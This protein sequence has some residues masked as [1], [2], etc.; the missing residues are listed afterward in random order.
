MHSQRRVLERFLSPNTGRLMKTSRVATVR[1]EQIIDAAIAVI[2]EQGIQ[3][4]SL[5]EIEKKTGL[6][7]GQLMYY[8]HSKEEILLAVF[9]RLL[10]L[11]RARFQ[12]SN[13][14]WCAESLQG[15]ERCRAFL[16]LFL[17]Q[18]PNFPAFHSLH[19]TFLSQ[20]GH[21]DDF[22]QRLA[23]L[24]D[25]WRVHMAGDL[26]ESLERKPGA[27]KASPRVLASLVQAIL[28]GL[29][30]QRAADPNCYDREE[31]LA[32]VLEL[33]DGYLQPPGGSPSNS[34]GVPAGAKIKKAG[35]SQ[36]RGHRPARAKKVNHE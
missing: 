35:A 21:R 28:H 17:L 12:A 26:Q 3:N 7:R 24:Y 27:R 32:L 15:W 5:S 31:M 20:I 33:L 10:Q 36:P 1:R 2:D 6:A 29:G 8:Y 13:G 25:A 4:L 11:M 18:P 34:H 22:R 16:T 14:A 30:V 19:H 9:D 23:N